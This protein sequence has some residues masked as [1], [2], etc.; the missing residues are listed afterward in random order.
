MPAVVVFVSCDKGDAAILE[1]CAVVKAEAE[2]GIDCVAYATANT[3]QVDVWV[4]FVGEITI[5]A[6][7]AIIEKCKELQRPLL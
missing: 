3:E 6:C 5:N 4:G 1:L 7:C 2:V